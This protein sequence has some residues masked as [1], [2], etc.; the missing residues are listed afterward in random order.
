[1]TEIAEVTSYNL[2]A[3]NGR[4][5]RVATRVILSNGHTIDFMERMSKREAIRQA[6]AVTA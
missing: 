3:S 5:I 2:T 6:Q 4:H 1:M